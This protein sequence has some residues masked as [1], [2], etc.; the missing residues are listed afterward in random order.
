MLEL[1]NELGGDLIGYSGPTTSSEAVKA[2]LD[3]TNKLWDDLLALLD[4]REEDLSIGG[5]QAKDYQVGRA[6]ITTARSSDYH[7]VAKVI[8]LCKSYALLHA[9]RFA[10]GF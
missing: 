9:Y 10:S 5:E 7:I 2:K 4:K 6:T 1:V 3:D 8:E